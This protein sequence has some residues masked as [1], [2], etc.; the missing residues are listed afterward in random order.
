MR[1]FIPAR[2]A[3]LAAAA[4]VL[5]LVALVPMAHAVDPRDWTTTID[6]MSRDSYGN[7]ITL[8]FTIAGP[9]TSYAI[10]LKM[11]RAPSYNTKAASYSSLSYT[12]A[13]KTYAACKKFSWTSGSSNTHHFGTNFAFGGP[14]VYRVEWYVPDVPAN[15]GTQVGQGA[16][17]KPQRFAWATAGRRWSPCPPDPQLQIGVWRPSRH[18]ILNRCYT[19]PGEVVRGVTTSSLD[20][21]HIWK[22]GPDSLQVE[23]IKRD[24][25]YT[26]YLPSP[27]VGST[28][29]ITGVY[30]CDTYHGW[31][32]I[33]PV[34]QAADSTGVTY[35]TGP[36]YSTVTPS[37]SG[38]WTPHS[39]SSSGPWYPADD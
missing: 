18:Q 30:V 32:E 22:L 37:V 19:L 26:T 4:G 11:T 3:V 12:D 25:Y 13:G 39:C 23:Y 16:T 29:T 21:D 8:T 34:F 28:W 15:G 31:Y 36:Q 7:P 6:P 2:I 27:S 24:W 33:H 1:R 35:L 14:G 38:S 9:A 10:C 17:G 5:L 20:Y